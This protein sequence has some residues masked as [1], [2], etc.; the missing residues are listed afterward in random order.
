[1][2]ILINIGC[3][4]TQM[5]IVIFTDESGV[6][7]PEIKMW[8]K[9]QGRGKHIENDK[10][11][12]AIL[13][14]N[15]LPLPANN[16]EHEEQYRDILKEYIRPARKMFTGMFTEVREFKEQLAEQAC[17][18]LHII[19]GRY[20]LLDENELIVPYVSNINDIEA[21]K[22]LDNRTCFSSKMAEYA[23]KADIIIMLLPIHYINYLMSKNWFTIPSY[24]TKIIM[25]SSKHFK[26]QFSDMPN[27]IV[28]ERKGVARIGATNKKMIIEALG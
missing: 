20:G 22:E 16:M 1:M 19:S 23:N 3:N 4:L 6:K 14:E 12:L 10:N 17:V 26:D 11:I 25:V 9:T 18:S 8:K 15:T 24:M 7:L 5:K 13:A 2:V 27:I 21:L 28:L